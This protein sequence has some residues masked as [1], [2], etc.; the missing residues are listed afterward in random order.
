MV[1]TTKGYDVIVVGLGGM[2]S[3]AA[4]HLAARGCRVLGLEQHQPAHDEGSSHGGSR[5]IRQSYF[6]DPGYVPLLLRAYELW[7]KLAADSQRDVYRV[8][9]GLFIGSPDCL[10]VSGSLRASR[11]WDLPHELLDAAEITARFPNFTPHPEDIALYDVKAGFARPELT[12]R[13]YLEIAEKAGATLQFGEPV[14]E[15]NQTPTGMQVITGRGSYTA[16]QLV[17]CPGA[18][19]PQVLGQLGVPI[20]VERQVMYWLDPIGG[21]SGFEDHPIFIHENASGIHIYGLPAIDGPRGGVKVG[22]ARNGIAC[23]PDTIDRVVHEREISEVRARV[24]EL[25]PTLAGNCLRA[26][27]CMYSNTPDRHFVI[28]R[29]PQCADIIMACGFSGHG[30]KFVPVVGEILADLAV[31]RTTDQLISLFDPQRLP[32]A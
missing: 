24:A 29:H 18:W 1:I 22:F 6:E 31:D 14:L 16:E 15:W 25:L 13:A 26:V 27:T 28:G 10:T 20:T 12:V 32:T 2:G 4:Y 19:A 11:Q 17:I 9:G 5:I 3:A 30:F 21:A 8:T 7:E 23:T